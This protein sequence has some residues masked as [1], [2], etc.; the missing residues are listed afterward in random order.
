MVGVAVA[1]RDV[2][3]EVG[4]AGVDVESGSD[5]AAVG[6]GVAIGSISEPVVGVEEDVDAG[7]VAVPGVAGSSV[8]FVLSAVGVSVEPVTTSWPES[9]GTNI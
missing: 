6:D 5:D 1:G 7:V 3:L 9:D 4:S 8:S 2:G